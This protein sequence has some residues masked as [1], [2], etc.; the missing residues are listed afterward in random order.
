VRDDLTVNAAA[1]GSVY[2]DVTHG[3]WLGPLLAAAALLLVGGSAA[4][5]GTDARP[6]AVGCAA[7]ISLTGADFRQAT[8]LDVVLL[9]FATAEGQ[10]AW[11]DAAEPYGG[12]YLVGER[13]ALSGN[14]AERIQTLQATLGGTIEHQG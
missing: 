14:S 8:C 9:D 12:V 7:R 1:A 10:R 13:W 11:L 5:I 6:V 3:R 2:L 4:S